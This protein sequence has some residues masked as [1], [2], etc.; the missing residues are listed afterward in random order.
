MSVLETIRR[1]VCTPAS[2]VE[3]AKRDPGW[4]LRSLRGLRGCDL[5]ASDATPVR[6]G[7]LLQSSFWNQRWKQRGLFSD[8]ETL[9]GAPGGEG[10]ACLAWTSCY[11]SLC[12]K[13]GYSYELLLLLVHV[14]G[15][16]SI[17]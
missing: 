3:K 11:L 1:A 4:A 2:A 7:V 5:R 9:C 16:P 8:S 15:D 10:P 6:R 14:S 17:V 12:S 13:G